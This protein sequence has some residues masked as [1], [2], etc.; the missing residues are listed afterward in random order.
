MVE[1]DY[2]FSSISYMKGVRMAKFNS[3]IDTNPNAISY[4]GG[5]AYEKDAAEEWLNF[6]MSSYIE[7]TYYESSSY[8]LKCFHDLTID[9]VIEYGAEFVAKAANFARNELGMR[10][11]AQYVAAILNPFRFNDKRIFYKNFCHRPDDVA[12]IFAAVK[13]N[14]DKR[15]HAMVRGFSDYLSTLS[16]Y[17][18]GKYKLNNH[19]FNMYDIINITHA[20]SDAI[21]A[22]KA[23][24]LKTPDTWETA[25]SGAKDVEERKNEWVR[26][27][28]ENKLGYLALIRNLRNILSCEIS[29]EWIDE[30]LV[31]QIEN[32]HAIRK[33]MVFPYQIYCAYKNMGTHNIAVTYA[34]SNAFR[35]ALVDNMPTLEG[36]S[37]V[38]LDVSA[39]MDTPISKNSK[40][41]IREV[42]AVYAICIMLT[43]E[44]SDFI[45]F[46]S[47]AKTHKANRLNNIFE[48]I[49][50]MQD[51]DALG[52]GTEIEPAYKLIQK[53]YDRIIL[54]S[55]MQVMGKRG[56]Y[57]GKGGT[58]CYQEYCKRFG[59]TP[60]Y[61]FD[62]GNYH[63]QTD[64]PNNPDV[65]LC[66]SLS[67]KTLKLI[68]LLENGM[69]LVDYINDNYD[70]R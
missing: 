66:T 52:F 1:H 34:L 26:L 18:L 6:L 53:K 50:R 54:I 49:N 61:S 60:I 39:S 41:T 43:S 4:E 70:Y 55:D 58:T 7:D 59:R 36:N 15:S 9:M 16:P 27:V 29:Q 68:S 44:N 42:G 32:E 11:A 21:N 20:N 30:V 22:Y 69:K 62:L 48:E 46:G 25:I 33:S 51:N 24:T 35:I 5:K 31:P 56:W 17:S 2:T 14:G 12:E 23:G 38:L 63:T 67:E 3:K 64:N 19:D 8:Q 10:S 47:N 13:S 40:I 57:Y 45:K 37:V 28:E 65:H